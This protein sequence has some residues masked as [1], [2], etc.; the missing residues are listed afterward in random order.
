MVSLRITWLFE[1]IELSCRHEDLYQGDMQ[2]TLIRSNEF[3]ADDFDVVR[4]IGDSRII[5]CTLAMLSNPL[6]DRCGAFRYRP[7]EILVVD[8]ASQIDTL[9]FM[10]SIPADASHVRAHLRDP[11]A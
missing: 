6:L 2:K 3:S 10:V 8:E 4:R 1:C 9:E 11:S 7:M 5:L